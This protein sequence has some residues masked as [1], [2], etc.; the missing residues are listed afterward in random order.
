[1][2]LQVTWERLCSQHLR[3][4]QGALPAAGLA[5]SLMCLHS[6]CLAVLLDLTPL[7]L[8]LVSLGESS[9]TRQ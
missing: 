3:I 4:H 5:P 8:M 1:M 9:P 6:S 2:H 7:L